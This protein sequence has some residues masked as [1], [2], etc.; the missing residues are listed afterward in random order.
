MGNVFEFNEVDWDYWSL[1]PFPFNW[2]VA[3][4][5]CNIPPDELNC[6]DQ[7]RDIDFAPLDWCGKEAEFRKKLNLISE[8]APHAGYDASE[9]AGYG[10]V[11]MRQFL[12]WVKV[13][14][15]WVL[16][17]ELEEIALGFIN[18]QATKPQIQ[19]E[20]DFQAKLTKTAQ[21]AEEERKKKEKEA[22][23]KKKEE[24][25]ARFVRL[26]ELTLSESEFQIFQLEEQLNKELDAAG[27][28]AVLKKALND[29]F[30]LDKTEIEKIA[31][32]KEKDSNENL[33]YFQ[34]S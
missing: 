19:A 12:I 21:D 1:M 2:E 29:K 6:F 3:G 23:D 7:R 27:N 5:V 25:N 11:D 9:Q 18:E 13:R 14:T 33:V 31:P 4:L 26:Q 32:D 10:R 20:K 16:P 30:Q 8:N 28:N 34:N 24:A 15:K 22:N 17:K